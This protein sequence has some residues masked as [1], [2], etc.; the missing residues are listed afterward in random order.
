MTQ[1]AVTDN[2]LIRGCAKVKADNKE[3]DFP[4]FFLA[5]LVVAFL[6][7]SITHQLSHFWMDTIL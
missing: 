4:F 2:L 5:L 6:S 3:N 7:K 1:S